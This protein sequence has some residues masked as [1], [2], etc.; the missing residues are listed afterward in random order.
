MRTYESLRYRLVQE[1]P[2]IPQCPG[3]YGDPL[4]SQEQPPM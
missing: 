3:V 2:D 4:L 1:G